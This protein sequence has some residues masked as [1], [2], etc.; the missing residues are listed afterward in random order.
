LAERGGSRRLRSKFKGPVLLPGDD[1]YD[2]ARRIWNG[3]VDRRPALIARCLDAADASVVLQYAWRHGLAVT[4]RGGGHNVAGRALVDGAVLV[5]LSLM[6]NVTVDARRRI[7]I[8]DGGCLLRDLDRATTVYNLACPSGVVSDTGLGGL[9][10]GG[11]YGW[12]ARKWG[13]TCD[14]I[15]A[16]DVVLTDGTVVS[17]TENCEP[18]LLWALRG[19]GG[20]VGV[21]TRFTLALRPVG[22][23]YIR[24]LTYHLDE[25]VQAIGGYRKFAEAQSDSLHAVAALKHSADDGVP[26]LSVTV[27]WLGLPG[28]GRAATDPLADQVMPFRSTERV[29]PFLA[30]QR[31]GDDGEPAG[32]RY[33]TKSCY[34]GGLPDEIAASLVAA[35]WTCP[36]PRSSIDFEFL[37]GAINTPPADSA[38][39]HREAPY[40]CTASA[41]WTVAAEDRA[42]IGWARRTIDDL[43]AWHHGGTYVNYVQ[44]Q[45]DPTAV[46]GM[47]EYQRLAGVKARYDA[48][49]TLG[50]NQMIVS[51]PN[52]VL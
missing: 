21:V 29:L 39:P 3:M 32:H 49:N 17:A 52:E 48:S 41:Q 18:D 9:A 24:Q 7:A 22:E 20:D 12:L 35:A 38:F 6:R 13:L 44:D 19:G 47:H 16:A 43:I 23:V 1:G 51:K 34:L 10:L 45:A 30:L 46:Y 28:D 33:F 31:L 2:G 8:A 4:I 37:L 42:N 15:V 11:G 27:L 36:S 5:D 50:A 26:V 14:H 25:G 40:L